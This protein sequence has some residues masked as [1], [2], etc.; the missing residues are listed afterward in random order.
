[1][2]CEKKIKIRVTSRLLATNRSA[3]GS[4]LLVGEAKSQDCACEMY[5]NQA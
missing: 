2:L 3:E 4:Q 5:E 1:M